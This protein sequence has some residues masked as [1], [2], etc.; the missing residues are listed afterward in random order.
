MVARFEI[1]RTDA[2]QPWHA[3]FIAA[4]GRKVWTTENYAS[5]TTALNAI[6]SFIE[7]MIGC[8][9][10]ESWYYK[11][12]PNAPLRVAPA[13]VYRKSP[14]EKSNGLRLEIRI[15]DERAKA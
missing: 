15:V 12:R 11:D 10:E 7:P 3:R 14:W 4:N 1:V 9:V 6:R 2:P 13:V 5:K 8:W